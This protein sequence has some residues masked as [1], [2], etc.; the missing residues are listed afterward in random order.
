MVGASLSIMLEKELFP[1]TPAAAPV[2]NWV[3]VGCGLTLP[4]LGVGWLWRV[5]LLVHHPGWRLLWYL[6]ARVTTGLLL[7]ALLGALVFLL[8]VAFL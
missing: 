1:N 2:A 8:R 6:A 3:L 4:P 5:A 7:V